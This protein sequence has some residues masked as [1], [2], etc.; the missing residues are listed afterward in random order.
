M[1][2]TQVCTVHVICLPIP[3]CAD[4]GE[5]K[6]VR[7]PVASVLGT[8]CFAVRGIFFNKNSRANWKVSWHQDCVIAVREKIEIE[9]WGPWSCKAHVAHVRPAAPILEHMLA[10]RIHLDDC[11]Y[12]NGPLR[13]IAGSHNQGFLSGDQIQA[14]P[15]E[16]AVACAVRR[17]DAILMRPLLLHASSI[18]SKPTNR[19]VVHIEF[20]A[21]ELPNGARW[22]DRV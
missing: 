6:E 22:H 2:L 12:D 3:P 5:R 16:T 18:A 8:N 11:G 1:R 17:G 21:H 20:A 14:W 15:K 9:G 4:S 7:D 13:V 19:R 10:I